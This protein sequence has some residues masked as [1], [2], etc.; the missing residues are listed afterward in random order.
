MGSHSPNLPGYPNRIHRRIPDT[1]IYEQDT[2]PI[3]QSISVQLM[4]STGGCLRI[5]GTDPVFAGCSRSQA[6]TLL[7]PCLRMDDP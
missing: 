7:D 1:S 2:P 5:G 4:M 6:A 3:G